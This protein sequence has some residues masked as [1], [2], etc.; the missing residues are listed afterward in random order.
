MPVTK[1]EFGDNYIAVGPLNEA[2]I[3]TEVEIRE[4][5][6]GAL[7]DT[8]NSMRA[9]GIGVVFGNWLIEGYPQ[10]VL[11]DM[12]SALWRLDQWKKELWEASH[13]GPFML[14]IKLKSF[15][16]RTFHLSLNIEILID[17]SFQT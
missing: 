8:V 5:D 7:R 1:R 14:K 3:R 2:S 15:S 12:K 16:R 13:I 9:A 6:I 17:Y 11:F 4:P 10:V